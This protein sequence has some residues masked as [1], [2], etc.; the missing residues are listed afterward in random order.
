MKKE[1]IDSLVRLLD[2]P[3]Y[4]V[5]AAVTER[6]MNE[7]AAIVPY[8]ESVWAQSENQQ[9]QYRIEQ[10]L[11]QLQSGL[12][13]S[14]LQEW[15]EGRYHNLLEGAYWVARQA[16]PNLMIAPLQTALDELVKDVWTSMDD[17]YTPLEKIQVLNHFFYHVH[18][19]GSAKEDD[20][21]RPQY[22]Y[23]HRVIENKQ[24]NPVSLSL[25]YL[26]VAQQAGLP[27]QAVCLPR[28]FLLAYM[29]PDN[30]KLLFYINPFHLGASLKKTD[31]DF[32]FREMNITPRPEF[33][34]PCTP[35]AAIRRL[36]EIQLF[37]YTRE[38]NEEKENL[39]RNLLSLF[40]SMKTAFMEE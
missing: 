36:V 37:A 40:G 28:N 39:F 31:I 26:Y 10:L 21:L 25:L 13:T 8:L 30:E 27:L 19:Y 2:D 34:K 14:G 15:I 4:V 18:G 17:D 1:E 32:Y 29:A 7:G 22:G 24:G 6:L 35:C 5:Y 11:Q 38:G 9:Q 23:I 12:A 20:F 16:Y 3:D 33:Y